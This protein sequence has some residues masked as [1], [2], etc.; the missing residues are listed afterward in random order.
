[1]QLVVLFRMD[2]REVTKDMLAALAPYRS[3][4][5]KRFGG[6]TLDLEPETHPLDFTINFLNLRREKPPKHLRYNNLT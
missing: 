5:I 4:H 2:G 3:D 1:M 6:Y